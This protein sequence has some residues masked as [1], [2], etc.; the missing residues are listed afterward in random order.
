MS[1][2]P[3]GA[4]VSLTGATEHDPKVFDNYPTGY[5]LANRKFCSDA[6]WRCQRVKVPPVEI[7][8]LPP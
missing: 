5:F 1:S 8:Q 6:S 7:V 3:N 4:E 2:R